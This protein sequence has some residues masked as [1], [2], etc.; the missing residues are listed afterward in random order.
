VGI[1]AY[2]RRLC[3]AIRR[4]SQ[5]RR[6]TPQS[7]VDMVE[8]VFAAICQSRDIVA[9]SC[10][11]MDVRSYGGIVFCDLMATPTEW[12]ADL[13]IDEKVV[14]SDGKWVRVRRHQPQPP[15][16]RSPGHAVFLRGVATSITKASLRD[17]MCATLGCQEG[18][19]DV[20]ILHHASRQPFN[21]FVAYIGTDTSIGVRLQSLASNALLRDCFLRRLC[22]KDALGIAVE[23]ARRY[24]TTGQRRAAA[25]DS[26]M[27]D[28]AARAATLCHIIS[29]DLGQATGQDPDAQQQLDPNLCYARKHIRKALLAL[30][31]A[32]NTKRTPS[33]PPAT[34][35]K[36]KRSRRAARKRRQQ[37]QKERHQQ[38]KGKAAL[39]PSVAV[40]APASAAGAA[41][42]SPAPIIRPEDAPQT[43]PSQSASPFRVLTPEEREEVLDA[44]IRET[45]HRDEPPP[46]PRPPSPPRG[47]LTRSQR[48]QLVQ[49]K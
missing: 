16:A 7:R 41:G 29:S 40:P 24:R 36:R 22:P 37:K 47:V 18:D 46:P 2:H 28:I 32:T 13:T 9:A 43:P 45:L 21:C 23:A 1:N 14:L 17:A 39:S 38:L 12:L 30:R 48:A 4:C 26:S 35:S 27:D 25:A 10:V 19:V 34:R 44:A 5:K 42:S 8:E 49:Q 11:V 20:V 31:S 15:I 33:S 3:L 6:R